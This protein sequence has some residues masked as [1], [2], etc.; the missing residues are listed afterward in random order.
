M[1]K[2]K[3]LS[4]AEAVHIN[5][6]PNFNKPSLNSGYEFVSDDY[7]MDNRGVAKKVSKVIVIDPKVE[8]SK[9]RVSDFNL[10]NII[11]AGAVGNLKDMSV[12]LPN[13]EA[14]EIA[15]RVLDS[16]ENYENNNDN[17]IDE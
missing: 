12:S 13:M 16:Y 11:A 3:V 9:Y 10:E 8:M 6:R 4:H 1:T 7:V 14:A 15:D 5:N 17:N 2:I